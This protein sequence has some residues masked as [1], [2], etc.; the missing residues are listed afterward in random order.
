MNRALIFTG[1]REN[2]ISVERSSG[3][4]R[5]AHYLRS[6][7]WDIEVIDFIS[8]WSM[9]DL[10]L[11]IDTRYRQGNLKWIGVSATWIIGHPNLRGVCSYI[12]ERYPDVVIIA[13]GHNVFSPEITANYYVKGF[14]EAAA[15]AILDY[16]FG[17][18]SKPYG[19]PYKSGWAIDALHFYPC[20]TLDNYSIDYEIRDFLEP[21]DVLTLELSR[22]CRFACKFCNFP[23]LG[24]KEDYS[25]SEDVIFNNISSLYDT[26]GIKN[27]VVADETINDRNSKLEKLARAVQR[28]NIEPNLNAF[29]RIDLFKSH[30]EQIKLLADARVWGHFY[31]IETFNHRAGKV[32]GKGLDPDVIKQLMLNV[33]SYMQQHVGPYRGT[34]SFISGL[35]YETVDDLK[36]T[37]DWLLSNWT[38]QHWS[39]WALD[40]PKNDD[41]NKLSAFGEDFGKYGYSE[42]SA[43][44]IQIEKSKIAESRGKNKVMFPNVAD[45]DQNLYWKNPQGNKFTFVEA[46]AAYN[47]VNP[48]GAVCRI[49]NYN[50]WSKISLGISP[51]EALLLSID[52]DEDT[53][54]MKTKIQ[55]YI[56]KKLAL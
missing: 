18:G 12:K 14:G 6:F 16:E 4:Y 9:T 45:L 22:G 39:I 49:G 52:S 30:P 2:K 5:M 55:S 46:A 31:G 3:A 28:S 10:Q 11:L 48:D 8:H 50:V 23:I 56:Q 15:K 21:T 53:V 17:N 44:E 19:R 26:W 37:H 20:W 41:N 42:M 27:F 38:D 47:G 54:I 36:N 51:E 25:V 40:I 13:G 34:A 32:I 33:K 29:V 35:P 43:E 7:N 24:V 1:F